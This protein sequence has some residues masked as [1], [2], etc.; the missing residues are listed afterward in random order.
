MSIAIASHYQPH[1]ADQS[2][3]NHSG[4]SNRNMATWPSCLY[5]YVCSWFI[6]LTGG[7][8]C[9]VCLSAGVCTNSMQD[10]FIDLPAKYLE[11]CSFKFVAW[12][13]LL[14]TLTN[15]TVITGAQTRCN[16]WGPLYHSV[17]RQVLPGRGIPYESGWRQKAP[18]IRLHW[19]PAVESTGVHSCHAWFRVHRL[20]PAL[21]FTSSHRWSKKYNSN[22]RTAS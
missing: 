1:T 14:P 4:R 16:A 21:C 10:T 11:V 13:P 22:M 7:T 18:K 17:R 2:T 19:R 5:V 20:C 3:R 6:F 15:T 9:C 8:N 12:S